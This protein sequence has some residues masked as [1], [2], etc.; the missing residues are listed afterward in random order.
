MFC[1]NCRAE[2]RPG[3]TKCA[4]CAIELVP[5][6]L[7]RPAEPAGD[8]TEYPPKEFFFWFVPL[9]CLAGFLPF[10]LLTRLQVSGFHPLVVVVFLVHTIVPIGGWWLIYQAVR[11][12]IR[13]GRYIL[14]AF[15]PFGFLWYRFVRYP[16]RP[17]LVRVPRDHR[18]DEA[19]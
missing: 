5:D 15:I 1:P 6:L 13:V 4:D 3:F 2:Y 10:Y 11:Y 14:L 9:A 18:P 19:T 8:P 17:K 12:E 7:P 16:H